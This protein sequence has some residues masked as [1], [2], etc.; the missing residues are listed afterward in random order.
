MVELTM[1][2]ILPSRAHHLSGVLQ[3]THQVA[4]LAL[5]G[6]SRSSHFVLSFVAFIFLSLTPVSL[7]AAAEITA[8]I[9]NDCRET[10]AYMTV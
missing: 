8:I 3:R 5:D 7:H 10:W 9:Y 4:V 2:L 1:T 6:P